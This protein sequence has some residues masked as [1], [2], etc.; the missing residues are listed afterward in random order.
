MA[1]LEELVCVLLGLDTKKEEEEAANSD[2]NINAYTTLLIVDWKERM[3][4]HLACYPKD[5]DLDP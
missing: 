2:N 5:K 1:P 3:A 4:L